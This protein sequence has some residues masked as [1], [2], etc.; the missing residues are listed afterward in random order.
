MSARTIA[1]NKLRE[2][3]SWPDVSVL[4]DQMVGADDRRTELELLLT[5]LVLQ[6]AEAAERKATSRVIDLVDELRGI[7][8]TIGA[9]VPKNDDVSV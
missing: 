3:P 5:L 1:M 4:L 9:N 8:R 2:L 7:V 6:A